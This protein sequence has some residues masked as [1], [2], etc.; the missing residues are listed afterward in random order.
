MDVVIRR[1]D[2]SNALMRAAITAMHEECYDPSDNPYTPAANGVWWIAFAGKEEAAFGGINPAATLL[3]AGYL[4]RAG[5][6]PKFQGHGLQ[7]RLIRTRVNYA[8]KQGWDTVITDTR[9]N[10]A[11]SNSLISCGF[12]VYKPTAPWGHTDAIYW[13]KTL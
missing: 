12:K 13:R 7:K 4:C 6:L 5:V 3:N 10:P 1:V 8:R 2:I 11:S 9:R